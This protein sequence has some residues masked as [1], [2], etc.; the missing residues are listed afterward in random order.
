MKKN[1]TI[2]FAIILCNVAI[3]QQ[4]NMCLP[5]IEGYKTLKCDFY[6][7][8]VFSDGLVI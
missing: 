5:N 4:K 1:I 6:M 8:T 2:T 3:A 7:H